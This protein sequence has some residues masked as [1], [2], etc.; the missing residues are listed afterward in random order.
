MKLAADRT[1]RDRMVEQMLAA[2]KQ[3]TGAQSDKDKDF[4]RRLPRGETLRG[5]I[6]ALGDVLYQPA[7]RLRPTGA[8][9]PRRNQNCGRC[10][11]MKSRQ[12][13]KM[14]LAGR[15]TCCCRVF[16]RETRCHN[17]NSF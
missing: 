3:L 12:T 13:L 11:Q 6:D 17:P 10:N 7:P 9:T 8:L 2:K 15:A 16:Y 4:L 14:N 1:R 5:Q